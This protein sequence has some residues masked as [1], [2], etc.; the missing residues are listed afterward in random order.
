[1][2]NLNKINHRD[3]IDFM[4]ELESNSIQVDIIVTSSPYN[5]GKNYGTF[6]N[7]NKS[8]NEY[9]DF[10]NEVVQQIKKI[11]KDNGSQG[12]KFEFQFFLLWG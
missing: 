8:R 1:M 2:I 10:I 3:C 12:G 9:L 4:Q 6:Y 7:D 11:L 5:I